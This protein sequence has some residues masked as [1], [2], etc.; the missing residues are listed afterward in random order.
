MGN[1]RISLF[2]PP[3]IV[4]DGKR[5]QN[6]SRKAMALLA[7]L[8]MRAGERITRAHLSELLWADSPEEQART[9]L[10]QTLSLLRKLF[11]E[12][13]HDP[14]L[15]PF[16]Q[17]VMQPDGFEIEAR[18]CLQ[19]EVIQNAAELA[20]GPSFLEGFSVRAPNFETWMH[21]QRYA[22]E[23]R[24]CEALEVASEEMLRSRDYTHAAGTLSLVLKL[25][26]L[27]ETAYRRQMQALAALG[28]TDAALAQYE[29]CVAILR[30]ELQ[31]EPDSETRALAASIRTNRIHPSPTAKPA[32]STAGLIVS[33]NAA[34]ADRRKD[35]GTPERQ[36]PLNGTA[37]ET[38]PGPGADPF[39]RFIE[40]PVVREGPIVAVMPFAN[41]SDDD[42]CKGFAEG[43]SEDLIHMLSS[44]RWFRVLA[45]GSTFSR[46]AQG[47][48]P[49]CAHETF[50]ADYLITG[51]VRRNRQTIRLGVEV[52]I[53]PEGELLWSGRYDR[54]LEDLFA[55]ED[56]IT[57]E[58]AAAI[59][60][61]LECNEVK[62]VLNRPV[63]TMEAYDLL[64]RGNWHLSLGT[65]ESLAEAERCFE[66]AATLNPNSAA[67][68]AALAFYKYRRAIVVTEGDFRARLRDCRDA[69]AQS[70]RYDPYNPCALRYFGG[71]ATHL[72][73]FDEA[74]ETL[75]RSIEFCPNYATAY[76][77][78]AFAHAKMGNFAETKPALDET[79]RLRPHDQSLFRCVITKSIADYQTGD[80]V[81]AEQV[82]RDSLRGGP[83]WL[84][85]V[86]LAASLGQQERSAEAENSVNELAKHHPDLTL[87]KMMEMARFSNSAHNEHLSEGLVKAGWRDDLAG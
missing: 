78:L 40:T 83:W 63:E 20:S 81:Q 74:M 67:P 80:Y 35:A 51:N 52:A 54:K 1:L 5:F 45:S 87:D 24:L 70:L 50:G 26:P 57:L 79:L 60:P 7:Y 48:D 32:S 55:L 31:T 8:A 82:A 38:M 12:A 6:S 29:S 53:C 56:E 21:A 84:S 18:T 58:I 14:I 15:V 34:L 19:G 77:G 22:I 49:A 41:L 47:I 4:V 2:G 9:N 33:R 66:M 69:A 36:G 73:D 68:Y 72:T 86:M 13:G 59:E 3:A 39:H 17:V 27:R 25:D 44:Y 23:L 64:V 65:I 10:R 11:R 16:D 28:R 75:K 85:S 76:S 71:A 61:A 62:R 46:R 42:G 37:T 43:L 30:T